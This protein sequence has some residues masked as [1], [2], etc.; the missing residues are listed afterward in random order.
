VEGSPTQAC[1]ERMRILLVLQVYLYVPL[2][3]S[4]ETKAQRTDR[5]PQSAT[6]SK[7]I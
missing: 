5:K 7:V 6:H 1:I 4:L 2:L 3:H